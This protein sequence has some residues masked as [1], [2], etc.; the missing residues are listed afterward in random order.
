MAL[1]LLATVAP[2]GA[3]GQTVIA[4]TFDREVI[5]KVSAR[6][7]LYLPRDYAAIGSEKYPLLFFLHG[8]GERGDDLEKV[9]AHGPPKLVAQGKEFPFIIVS[10]LAP[11]SGWSLLTLNGLFEHVTAKYRVDLDRV[12][13]TGLS[14]GGFAT[15]RWAADSPQ[16]FAAIV[17]IAGGGDPKTASAYRN[18]AIWAFHGA[19]DTVV[20]VAR[21]HEMI[22]AVT[23]IAGEAKLTVYPNSD[24]DSWTETYDNPDLYTWLLKHSRR[25]QSD[26]RR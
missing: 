23:G 11:E 24:H 13:L 3:Q 26:A 22:S 14:M 19:N 1:I 20:P 15:W 5:V 12:Y 21:N 4:E 18:L 9:K 10:P 2:S 17:P 6:Y 16:K 25:K 8:A 7:L